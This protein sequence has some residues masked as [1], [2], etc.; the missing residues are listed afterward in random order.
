MRAVRIATICVA[1]VSPSSARLTYAVSEWRIRRRHDA[2]LRAPA[3]ASAPDPVA[4]MHMAKLVGCWAGCHGDRGEGGMEVIEGI[5]RV[6]APTLT[7][8]MPQYSD[9]ELARL[10]RYG[11]KR[12]GRSAVGMA[13]YTWWPLGDQDLADIFAHLRRQAPRPAVQRTRELT[14]RG[15]VG[16]AMGDWKVSADQV[17][18]TRPRWGERPRRNAF[19]RGRYL[20]S[21]ICSECHGLDFNGFALEGG[22]SLVIVALY[23]P[24]EF[25]TLLHTGK[26]IGG[27]DIPKM[28][29][30][31]EVG[32][33]DAEIDDIYQFLRQYHVLGTASKPGP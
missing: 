6:T 30:M 21:V 24:D 7:Q 12:D 26:P 16:L 15:R 28:S 33:T 4:G 29:W 1:G 25:R 27:R 31:P 9:A 11:V 10:V 17:D 2:P 32:F 3:R 13:S 23:G 22:P 14:F 20:A 19:E 5:R 18:P 8:V